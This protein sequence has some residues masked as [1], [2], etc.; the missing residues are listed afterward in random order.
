MISLFLGKHT[1][2]FRLYYGR[3]DGGLL[4]I[5][6]AK[7]LKCS[8]HRFYSHTLIVCNK[9]GGKADDYGISAL[10]QDSRFFRSVNYFLCILGTNDKAVA[11]QNALVSDNM[12][13]VSREANC[14]YGA[15]ADALVAV[16]AV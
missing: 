8:A 16:F 4:D 3:A 7:L 1:L 9:R 15:V 12:R 10:K 13:L 2:V 6:K 11:A 14:F 5:E